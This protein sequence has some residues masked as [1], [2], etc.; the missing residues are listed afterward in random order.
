MYSNAQRLYKTVGADANKRRMKGITMHYDETEI[1]S[2]LSE[3][4]LLFKRKA[5]NFLLIQFYGNT[6]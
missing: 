6:I 3:H 1:S 4:A 5:F 2:A